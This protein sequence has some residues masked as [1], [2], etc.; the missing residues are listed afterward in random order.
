VAQSNLYLQPR[1]LFLVTRKFAF[2]GS[3]I[4]MGLEVQTLTSS[5]F[6]IL[7]DEYAG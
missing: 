4:L 6:G 2:L 7:V 3:G 1:P 5:V